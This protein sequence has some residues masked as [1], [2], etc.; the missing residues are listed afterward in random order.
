[1]PDFNPKN[2]HIYLKWIFG[3][4]FKIKNKTPKKLMINRLLIKLIDYNNRF[5]QNFKFVNLSR[6]E[7]NP[8]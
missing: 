3:D 8:G 4:S 2:I 7:E 6:S 1:M 5:F